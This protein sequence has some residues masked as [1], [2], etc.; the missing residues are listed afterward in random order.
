MIERLLRAVASRWFRLVL[1]LLVLLS[2]QTTLFGA[3]RPF[4]YAIQILAIFVACAGVSVD[5]RIGVL[6]GLTAGFMYDAV[7]ATPLGVSALVFA[8]VG[9]LGA[10]LVQ[11]FRD[12]PWWLRVVAVS[13]AAASGEVLMPLMKS[14][15]G[16]DGWLSVRVGAVAAVTLS[17]GL[18]LAWPLLALSRWTLQEKISLGR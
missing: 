14:V 17:G 12:P 18:V 15:V 11:P 10:T 8:M 13:I 7:L 4:G 5:L 3:M 16:L 9:A 1:V 6:A 2:L